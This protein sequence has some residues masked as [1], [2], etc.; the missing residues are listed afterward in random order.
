M[1]SD[2]AV[3][4]PVEPTVSEPAASATVASAPSAS[5]AAAGLPDV[6]RPAVEEFRSRL[7]LASEEVR[8]WRLHHEEVVGDP[9]TVLGAE[10]GPFAEGRVDPTRL[11]SLVAVVE[12]AD[13]VLHHLVALAEDRFGRLLRRGSGAFVLGVPPGGDLRDAVR[14]ALADLGTAFGMARAIRKARARR[15]DPDA[16][17]ELLHAWPFHRWL[18]EERDAAP[19]LVVDVAGRDLRAA[20]LAEF[21]DGAVRILL[22]VRGDADPAPLGRL[23]SP[24]VLVAQV[25]GDATSILERVAQ[26]DGPA[27]VALFEA[28]AGAL[29]FLHDPVTGVDVDR[30]RL[31]AAI[32]DASAARG[33]PGLADLTHLERLAR[34]AGGVPSADAA[35]SAGGAT[36]TP[37]PG[38]TASVPG[39]PS[40]GAS[41]AG[42]DGPDDVDRL[43]GW[44][45][46]NLPPDP[47]EH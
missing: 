9:A 43:A 44:L 34:P 8:A 7:A 33:R 16:D 39:A 36:G 35:A 30:E 13:P 41:G 47:V 15:F 24:G 12:E 1:P 26:H 20:G 17:H 5:A 28:D 21:L 38:P 6:L 32:A 25:V 11:A 3:P 40:P 45:L 18:P 42:S 37:A 14:D 4:A 31:D 10:L 19:P 27:V 2:R 22:R 23:V 29:E 46:S